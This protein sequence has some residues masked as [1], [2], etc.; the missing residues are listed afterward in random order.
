M[1]G[2]THNISPMHGIGTRTIGGR[3][4]VHS[5]NYEQNTNPTSKGSFQEGNTAVYPCLKTAHVDTIAWFFAWE[6]L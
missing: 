3:L 5:L 4:L 1:Y 2:P 6:N